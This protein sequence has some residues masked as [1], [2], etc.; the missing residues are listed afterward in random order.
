[1]DRAAV[2]TPD[3]VRF[4]GNQ[5]YEYKKGVR[6]LFLMTIRSE[7]AAQATGRLE[8]ES[9]C[10]CLQAVNAAKVNLF[11]GHPA[12]VEMA[13]NLAAKPL[14]RL[15]PEED[16]ILGTLLGYD[17]EQ[18]CRRFLARSCPRAQLPS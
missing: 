1:M 16:F 2:L 6:R 12:W 7:D 4:L 13:R 3:C 14:N 10:Y 11:F 8:R 15:S 9:V 18:Q 5:L 17:G